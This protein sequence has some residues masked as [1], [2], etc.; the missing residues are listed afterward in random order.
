[1]ALAPVEIVGTTVTPTLLEAVIV[2]ILIVVSWQL[3]VALAPI[4]MREIRSWGQSFDE[5]VDEIVSEQDSE[6]DRHIVRNKK[7]H[8]HEGHQKNRS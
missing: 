2:I 5:T 7:E 6:Q 4:I 3:G 8:T 1:M